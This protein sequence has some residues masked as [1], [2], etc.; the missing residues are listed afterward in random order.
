MG[1]SNLE[2]AK[3]LSVVETISECVTA[4]RSEIPYGTE[5][6]AEKLE[7][8]FTSGASDA[9]GRADMSTR[10]ERYLKWYCY[11]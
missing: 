6:S 3:I 5:P 7:Q 11:V 4:Y 1:S 9:T 8:W 10:S 2:A